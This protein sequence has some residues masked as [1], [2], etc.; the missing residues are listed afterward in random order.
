M[1]YEIKDLVKT[2]ML[3]SFQFRNSS[4]VARENLVICLIT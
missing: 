4:T 1:N 3:I 2:A